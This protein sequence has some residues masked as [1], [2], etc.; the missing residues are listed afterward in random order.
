ML[1]RVVRP[2]RV[3]IEGEGPRKGMMPV[4]GD[5]WLSRGNFYKDQAQRCCRS[6]A[7]SVDWTVRQFRRSDG[8]KGNHM[9]TME[10]AKKLVELC[11]QGKN[12]E[13]LDTLFADDVVSVEAVAMPGAQ[14]E[15][16]GLAAVKAK[17]EWWVNNH[18]VHSASVTG[19][20]PHGDRFIVGFE[21][22]VTNKPSGKR[23]KMAEAALYTVRNGKVVREEFFYDAGM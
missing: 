19:P 22:D 6:S 21:F 1:V 9:T 11:K 4:T 14:Q 10:I 17:G 13:A 23:M 12:A 20:W 7:E 8:P 2:G 16:K 3:R 18:E 5:A 15:A